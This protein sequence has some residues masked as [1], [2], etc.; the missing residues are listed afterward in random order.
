LPRQVKPGLLAGSQVH[1][2][3][4][5]ILDDLDRAIRDRPDDRFL[6]RAQSFSRRDSAL[7]PGEYPLDAGQI[8]EQPEEHFAPMVKRATRELGDQPA[9]VAIDGQAGEAVSFAED[10]SK[11]R[12]SPA[13]MQQ[14]TTQPHGR[15]QP[16]RPERLVER[17]VVPPVEPD[18]D[19]APRIVQAP[20]DEL[21]LKTDD[22]HLVAGLG[23]TLDA[24]DRSVERPGMA[25]E[26]GTGAARLQD[27]TASDLGS[28]ILDVGLAPA[29]E[30]PIAIQRSKT[31]NPRL[32]GVHASGAEARLAASNSAR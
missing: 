32:G 17:P 2:V 12:A 27:D 10:K 8:T 4:Q 31:R 15:F 28:G 14:V 5:V 9:I 24:I 11:R 26:E 19:R 23:I 18:L 30:V 6:A 25:R 29:Y 20:S 21:P 22:G 13:E 3:S 16:T 1:P 7:R